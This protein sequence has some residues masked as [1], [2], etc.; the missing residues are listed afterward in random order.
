MLI[1]IA[2]V[3]RLEADTCA[4][5]LKETAKSVWTDELGST[6]SIPS[7][8]TS[9][10]TKLL[11]KSFHSS[12][13][14]TA[15]S[16]CPS[17]LL[18]LGM[19]SPFPSATFAI[20]AAILNFTSVLISS[21]PLRLLLLLLLL[22]LPFSESV[23]SA[24]VTSWPASLVMMTSFQLTPSTSFEMPCFNTFNMK[25]LSALEAL[26]TVVGSSSLMSNPD[27]I[28]IKPT[29]GGEKSLGQFS[30]KYQS[31]MYFIWASQLLLHWCWKNDGSQLSNST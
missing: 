4:S 11:S 8:I 22:L 16:C 18:T 25:S 15:D 12:A 24:A 21:S 30:L 19:S 17:V 1:V 2:G 28:S 20:G 3:S 23:F 31:Y 9:L 6:S 27:S 26:L 7:L 10:V 29:A 13:L 14:R 5:V